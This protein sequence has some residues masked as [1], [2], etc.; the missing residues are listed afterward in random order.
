[1]VAQLAA[2][3]RNMLDD[4]IELRE[5]GPEDARAGHEEE[6]AEHLRLREWG[7]ILAGVKLYIYA[8]QMRYKS[9][10]DS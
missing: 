5:H 7:N 2:L 1:M 10:P 8:I 4:L 9:R 6:N 3:A